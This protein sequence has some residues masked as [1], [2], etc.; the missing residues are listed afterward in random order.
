[1]TFVKPEVRLLLLSHYCL[2]QSFFCPHF[3]TH[4]K[5]S[6][7][8][9]IAQISIN[10]LFKSLVLFYAVTVLVIEIEG[11]LFP[12]CNGTFFGLVFEKSIKS[13]HSTKL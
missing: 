13:L 7:T 9:P 6:E 10:V 3:P 1:M 12:L 8:P 2:M 4:S 11:F 5:N